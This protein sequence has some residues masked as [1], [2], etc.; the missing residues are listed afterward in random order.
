MDRVCE[1]KLSMVLVCLN[2]EVTDDTCCFDSDSVA[3]LT[4]SVLAQYC[5]QRVRVLK[6]YDRLFLVFYDR[7]RQLSVGLLAVAEGEALLGP[8][9]QQVF[10]KEQSLNTGFFRLN[11]DADVELSTLRIRYLKR[12]VSFFCLIW[13]RTELAWDKIPYR[14]THNQLTRELLDVLQGRNFL[15]AELHFLDEYFLLILFFDFCLSLNL[16]VRC[17]RVDN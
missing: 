8:T 1:V 13:Q 14:D 15:F 12:D 11:S 4:F 5:V 16:S 2:L 3:E 17:S 7:Q 9:D 6:D 10:T